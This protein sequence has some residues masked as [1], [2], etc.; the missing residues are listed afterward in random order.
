MQTQTSQQS[1]TATDLKDNLRDIQDNVVAPILM[2]YGR[3]IFVKF[4]DGAKTRAWL[5]NMFKHVNARPEEHGTRFTVNVGFT[6]EGLKTLRLSQRSL[7]SFP[8]A[9]RA[10]MRARAKAVGD[11]GP[12]APEL[13][14]GGLGGPDV[15]AMAWV[16]TDSDA[17]REEA[18]NHSR[19]NGRDWRHRDPV[20]PGYNGACARKRHR[21]RG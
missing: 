6:Y 13:W 19:R 1:L 8:Q 11:T 15:H 4:H 9:F 2:G 7:D 17:G 14:E 12:H 16:R 10:G 3:H 5:R 18:T 20:H 21:L